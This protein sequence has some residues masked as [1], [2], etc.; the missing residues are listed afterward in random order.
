MWCHH[1]LLLLNISNKS[2]ILSIMAIFKM[3][4]LNVRDVTLHTL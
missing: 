3:D 4:F 2:G 1:M